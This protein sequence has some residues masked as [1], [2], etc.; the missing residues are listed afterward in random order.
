[1]HYLILASALLIACY[2][3]LNLRSRSMVYQTVPVS[4]RRNRRH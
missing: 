2:S 4:K 1:M 3:I